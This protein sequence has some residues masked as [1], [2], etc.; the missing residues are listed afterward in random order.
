MLFINFA[1]DTADSLKSKYHETA[2]QYR[3][4]GINFLVGD[5]EASQRA[6]QYFGLKEDQVPLIIIQD[7][8]GKKFLKPNLEPED[9]ATW[10]KAYKD[11]NT[12]PYK[13]S[14]TIPEVNNEPV[15]VVVA[16][17]LQDIVFNS[18]KNGIVCCFFQLVFFHQLSDRFWLSP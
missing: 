1:S 18:R 7:N 11:G 16:D 15:K 13:K 2:E 14:E 3:Q 9:I 4:E 17:N 10:L 8:D 6:F 5:V 12:E